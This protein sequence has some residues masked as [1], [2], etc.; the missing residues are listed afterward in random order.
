[1]AG[2]YT[3][4]A[5]AAIEHQPG[6]SVTLRT[7]AA[8]AIMPRER[9]KQQRIKAMHLTLGEVRGR[10]KPAAVEVLRTLIEG[11]FPDRIRRAGSHLILRVDHA[12]VGTIAKRL[13]WSSIDERDAARM[14]DAGALTDQSRKELAAGKR[15]VDRSLAQLVAAGI[16]SRTRRA[17][18]ERSP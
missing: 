13:G 11:T 14:I 6:H 1:L 7:W 8:A 15:R 5:H 9:A 4:S 12:S 3:S 2:S 10:I 17:G 18:A 16:I